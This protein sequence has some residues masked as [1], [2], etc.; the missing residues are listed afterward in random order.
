M[1]IR[2]CCQF[3]DQKIHPSHLFL[4]HVATMCN[5]K[6][7]IA[8]DIIHNIG[9]Y[10][11]WTTAWEPTA[12]QCQ[13]TFFYWSIFGGPQRAAEDFFSNKKSRPMGNEYSLCENS[14]DASRQVVVEP[15]TPTPTQPTR[16]QGPNVTGRA[17]IPASKDSFSSVRLLRKSQSRTKRQKGVRKQTAKGKA[18]GF[19][20]QTSATKP[21]GNQTFKYSSR[22]SCFTHSPSRLS[23]PAFGFFVWRR[24]STSLDWRGRPLDRKADRCYHS[25]NMRTTPS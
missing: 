11:Q 4:L 14:S 21:K 15:V 22:H 13:R 23:H 12:S 6:K 18:Q 5:T 17:S 8:A 2:Q 10:I 16:T 20:I 9:T 3:L 24:I 25:K 19:A 7:L 1:L